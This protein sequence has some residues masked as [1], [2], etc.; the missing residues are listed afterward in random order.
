MLFFS[1]DFQHNSLQH[2]DAHLAVILTGRSSKSACSLAALVVHL[3]LGGTAKPAVR[4]TA[5]SASS[6]GQAWKRQ[7][8]VSCATRVQLFTVLRSVRNDLSKTVVK[9]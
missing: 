2:V 6:N 7:P 9:V 4:L 3:R 5:N 8:D 1:S